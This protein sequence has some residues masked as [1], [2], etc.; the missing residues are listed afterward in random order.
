MSLSMLFQWFRDFLLVE[1]QR[2]HN[3]I[4]IIVSFFLLHSLFQIE[5]F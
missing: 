2:Q 4:V 3:H 5:V 1:C